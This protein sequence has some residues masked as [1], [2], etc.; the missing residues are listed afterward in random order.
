[1]ACRASGLVLDEC[2]LFHYVN[3]A[4][5]VSTAKTSAATATRA[6]G[7]QQTQTETMC[8]T[9]A[10]YPQ[11]TARVKRVPTRLDTSAVNHGS[12]LQA[13]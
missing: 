7:Q 5:I 12:V 1:M 13:P 11:R 6:P 8:C 2:W 4:S 10:D 3:I 9:N